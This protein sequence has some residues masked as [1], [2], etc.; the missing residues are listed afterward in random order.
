M[1]VKAVASHDG[2]YIGGTWVAPAAGDRIEVVSPVSE[3][4]IAS[5]P[6]GSREDI[7]RAVAA[8]RIALESDPWRRMTLEDRI[9]I[10]TRLRNLLVDHAEELAEVITEEMGCPIS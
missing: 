1:T 7:D 2:L 4:V 6:A 5:V 8:A 9:G 3:E 10:L